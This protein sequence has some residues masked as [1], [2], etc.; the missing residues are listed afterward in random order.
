MCVVG[1]ATVAGVPTKLRPRAWQVAQ[2]TPETDAWFIEVA[3]FANWNVVKLVGEWQLSHAALPTGTWFAGS[4]FNAGGAMFAKLLPAP[5]QT[6]H[7][8]PGTCA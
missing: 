2:A 3:V 5:W 4:T 7:A 8:V 1:G 6:A